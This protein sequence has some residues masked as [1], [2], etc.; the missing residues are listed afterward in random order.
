MSS[1]SDDSDSDNSDSDNSD[2]DDFDAGQTAIVATSQENS[3]SSATSLCK[4][5]RPVPN[6]GD[7]HQNTTQATRDQLQ[8]PIKREQSI[9]QKKPSSQQPSQTGHTKAKELP[10]VTG[11]DLQKR[12]RQAEDDSEQDVGKDGTGQEDTVRKE[13]QEIDDDDGDDLDDQIQL[14]EMQ[15]ALRQAE[16]RLAILRQR[17]KRKQSKH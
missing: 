7:K 4:P 9:S 17:K 1:D 14:A 5:K 13:T 3:K 6:A 10:R 12:K 11:N 15:L 2:S 8:H 16:M